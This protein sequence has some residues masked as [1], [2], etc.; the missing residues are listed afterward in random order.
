M[1]LKRNR[2][3]EKVQTDKTMSKCERVTAQSL[4]GMYLKDETSRI[5]IQR[6]RCSYSE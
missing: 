3:F 5:A 1:K 4:G 6:S 2:K